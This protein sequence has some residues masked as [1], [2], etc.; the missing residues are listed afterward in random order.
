MSKIEETPELG[1]PIGGEKIS[2]PKKFTLG[3]GSK[4]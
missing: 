1:D 2:G 4:V 3:S